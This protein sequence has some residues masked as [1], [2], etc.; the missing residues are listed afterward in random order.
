MLC[1]WK[2]M[3]TKNTNTHSR[4]AN[5]HEQWRSKC[6]PTLTTHTQNQQHPEEA[7]CFRSCKV[8][9]IFSSKSLRTYWEQRNIGVIRSKTPSPD[10]F[11]TSHGTMLLLHGDSSFLLELVIPRGLVRLLAA[12]LDPARKFLPLVG[13]PRASTPLGAIKEGSQSISFFLVGGTW[14][15][16]SVINF[17]L[18]V[19]CFV[20]FSVN[21]CLGSVFP[22]LVLFC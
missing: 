19:R 18:R 16:S 2:N 8:L 6:R 21:V 22:F 14:P 11:P 12:L 1:R 9:C 4:L 15:V 17:P 5:Y 20:S 3:S 7:C 13:V 10:A